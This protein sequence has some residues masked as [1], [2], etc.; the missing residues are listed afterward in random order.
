MIQTPLGKSFVMMTK[1]SVRWCLFVLLLSAKATFAQDAWPQFRGPTGDGLATVPG[2]SQTRGLPVRWSETENVAWKTA[3]PYQ[4]WSTPVVMD[5][6]VWL[7]TATPDGHDFFAICV[8]AATGE[9]R[10]NQRLFHADNPEPLGNPMNCYASPSPAIEPGRVYVHFGSYGTACLDTKTFEV[11]WKRDDLPCRHFRGPGSSAILFENLL[12]LTM[13]GVDVQYLIALDKATG[14]T[15]WKTDR[16]A[17][18]NDLDEDGK[19][20]DE[21]DLRKAYSTP[22]VVDVN[23]TR[24]MLTVGA[25]AVYGYDPATG[26][27]LWKIKTPGFSGAAMPIYGRGLAFMISGFGK[28]EL[29]AI[30]PDGRGDV[31]DTHIVWKTGSMVPQTPSPVLVGDLFFMINDTG[32]VTCLEAASGKQVWR[33]RMRGNFA[34]SLLYGDGNIYCFSREGRATVFKAAR[35]YELVSTNTMASGFMASP[36]VSGKALFL[37]TKEHLYRIES[38]R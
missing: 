10:F 36:A 7:T 13:D 3:I 28:T 22:L 2:D 24:Q 18:W 34:A 35:Q 20:R 27:E 12:V 15:V 14:R 38:N 6:Q 5:G 1:R 11:L 16:T 30:R 29:M 23:G 21:G 4:G 31:T 37:R 17:E 8:D 9:I 25:K 32:T 19:P 26:R 33:E